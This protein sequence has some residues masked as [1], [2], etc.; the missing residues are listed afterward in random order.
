MPKPSKC[1]ICGSAHWST[2]PCKGQAAPKAAETAPSPAPE[3]VLQTEP[4]DS[5]PWTLDEAVD[6]VCD[7]AKGLDALEKRV[8]A[9]ETHRKKT[10]ERVRRHRAKQDK[11]TPDNA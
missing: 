6:W 7:V 2:Q 9:L 3:P 5:E 8:A 1:L 4:Q 10:R 11:D